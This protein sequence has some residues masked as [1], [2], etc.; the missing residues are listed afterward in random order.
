MRGC[1]CV[2]VT[3]SILYSL[4]YCTKESN[5]ILNIHNEVYSLPFSTTV[6]RDLRPKLLVRKK[7]DKESPS[8]RDGTSDQIRGER[9]GIEV[10]TISK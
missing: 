9:S 10:I 6:E 4:L 1:V 7:G 2:K 8:A 5:I 3:I